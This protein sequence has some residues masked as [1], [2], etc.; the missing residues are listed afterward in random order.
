MKELLDSYAAFEYWANRRMLDV[1]LNL[2]PVQQQQQ[3]TSSFPS[4][5]KTCLH[6][7]D[8][9]S[10][11][12]QRLHMHEN[13]EL[14]S[15]TFHPSMN[16]AANGLLKQTEEW[17]NWVAAASEAD[18]NREL[19]YKNLKGEPFIQPVKYIIL[20][21]SN[22]GTYHRGQLVTMLRQ[23]GIEQIPKTDYIDF[24]RM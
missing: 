21:L 20:H 16:D 18:L 23:L 7:W 2:A 4:L 1:I 9:S 24:S 6:M 14:P 13:I 5:Y 3:I 22:H 10:A 8:S 17:K 11:W 19:P 12:W 15:L